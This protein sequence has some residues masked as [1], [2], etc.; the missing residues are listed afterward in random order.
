MSTRTSTTHRIVTPP[1]A[2]SRAAAA[3]VARAPRYRLD[4][5]SPSRRCSVLRAKGDLDMTARA[6]FAATLCDLAHSGDHVVVD[7][8]EVTFMYSEV[9]STLADAGHTRPGLF[10]IVAP[11]RQVR[12][13]LDILAPGLDVTD[14]AEND[15]AGHAA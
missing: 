2:L 12:M 8:S 14:R 11:T 4:V 3:T 6:E 9:A 13:L 7:L 15:T 5:H 1:G 10:R